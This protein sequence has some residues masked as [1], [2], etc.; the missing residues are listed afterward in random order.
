MVASATTEM[1][2]AGSAGKSLRGAGCRLM[3]KVSMQFCATYIACIRLQPAMCIPHISL[4]E[5]KHTS[6]AS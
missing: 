3:G 5:P 1:A 6:G 2:R 4:F